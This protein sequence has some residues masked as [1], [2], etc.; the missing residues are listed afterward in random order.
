M[1]RQGQPSGSAPPADNPVP[2]QPTIKG[3]TGRPKVKQPDVF[4]GERSKL[5]ESLAQ[6]KVCFRLVGWAE[7][8]DTEKIEYTTSLPRG[9]AV[10]WMTP[11]IEDLK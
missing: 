11:Y 1:R 8:H 10:T 3:N 9:S 2:D 7:G 4:R 5:R 6:I